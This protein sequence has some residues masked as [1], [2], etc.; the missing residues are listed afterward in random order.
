MPFLLFAS[1]FSNVIGADTLRHETPDSLLKKAEDYYFDGKNDSAIL[2]ANKLL[3]SCKLDHDIRRQAEASFLLGKVYTDMGQLDSSTPFFIRA[4]S[5]FLLLHDTLKYGETNARIGYLYRIQK[6][7]DEALSFYLKALSIFPKSSNSFWIGFV[8]DHLGHIYLGRGNYYLA[9][10]H[11]QKAIRVFTDLDV[12]LNVG[13]EYNAMG[14]I[15]RKTN[16]QDKEKQAYID[17]IAIL[18]EVDESVFLAEAYSNLS[19]VYLEEGLTDE[20]FEMLEKSRQVYLNIDY[21]LGLCSYFAVQAFYYDHQKPP[22]NSKIIEFAKQGAAIALE[23]E[24]YQQYADACYYLG[25]AYLRINQLEDA[26]KVLEKGKISAEQYGYLYELES[27]LKVLSEVYKRL[28]KP[29]LALTLLEQHLELKDSLS[30]EEKIK[31]FTSLDLSFRFKQEQFRDSLAQVQAKNEMV[32]QHSKEIQI[33]QLRQLILALALL[34]IVIVVFLVIKLSRKRKAQNLVLDEKN[35]VINEALH[36]KELLLK[37]IH[38]RVKNNFQTLSSLLELQAK[39]VVDERAITNIEEGQSRIRSM[40]LI[41]QKLYQTSD[42]SVIDMQEYV[43]QLAAQIAQSFSMKKLDINVTANNIHLDIDT[44]IPLGLILNELITNSCKYA[45]SKE[46]RGGLNIQISQQGDGSY[47][48][49]HQDSGPGL[50]DG[51]DPAKVKS[52]GLRLV[53]R[54]AK[55]LHGTIQYSYENGCRFDITFNDT[56]KRKKVE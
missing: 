27:I 10:E 34:V 17:A 21:P 36:E 48:L 32:Y 51:L 2:I 47:L 22:D 24:S 19:E 50:P 41:H 39:E 46:E 49:V 37:E 40:A 3:E 25:T 56:T 33:Q 30:G 55:Q 38:H 45:F 11:F 44:S 26:R 13:G 14:L 7:D 4:D 52:L 29:G 35:K 20:G 23:H 28:H 8:N 42:L 31:E 5:L 16:D 1:F 15:Y 18:L 9:L 12:L 54:L 53:S 6:K 43:E